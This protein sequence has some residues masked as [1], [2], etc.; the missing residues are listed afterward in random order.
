VAE[1]DRALPYLDWARER[2][3][4]SGVLAEQFHPYSGEPISVC[5]LTW[6]HATLMTVISQ[7]LLRHAELTGAR[8]G[9]VAELVKGSD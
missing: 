1:L 4:P 8:S 5:P 6:S 7:Y 2:S 9:V 3:L